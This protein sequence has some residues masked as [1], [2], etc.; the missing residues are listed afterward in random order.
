MYVALKQ[1]ISLSITIYL[2]IDDTHKTSC[3]VYLE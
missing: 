3:V 2:L 1:Y